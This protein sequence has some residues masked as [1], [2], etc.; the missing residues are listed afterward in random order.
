LPNVD[1]KSE[2]DQYKG[3]WIAWDENMEH[4]IASADSYLELVDHIERMNLGNPH[5]LTAPG[6]HPAFANKPFELQE[7]ESP[8]ILHDIRITIPNP[9]QWLDAPNPH[10]GLQ[11][12]RDLIGTDQE[13]LIRNILRSI[14]NGIFS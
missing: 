1:V 6:D 5:M 11:K 4:V 10:L 12:P 13:P 2:L 9:D 8:D 14:W 3:R 7:G